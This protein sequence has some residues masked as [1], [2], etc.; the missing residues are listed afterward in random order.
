MKVQA[1]VSA[2]SLVL[3]S[4]ISVG[5]TSASGGSA[6]GG[7]S[8]EAGPANP[9]G[10]RPVEVVSSSCN[11]APYNKFVVVEGVCKCAKHCLQYSDNGLGDG[12]SGPRTNCGTP[13]DSCQYDDNGSAYCWAL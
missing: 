2:L 4:M 12:G 1:F 7:P 9:C 5:C 10:A 6:D 3:V 13:S 11:S 8:P